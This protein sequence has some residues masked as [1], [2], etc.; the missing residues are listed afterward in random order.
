MTSL[1]GPGMEVEQDK[2]S[3]SFHLDN[4]IMIQ[5]TLSEYQA[6]IKKFVKPEQ[7]PMQPGVVLKHD[8]CP[9]T[10]D[11]REQKVYCVIVAKLQFD[12]TLPSQLHSWQ[13]SVHQLE[14]CNG[15]DWTDLRTRIGEIVSPADPLQVLW[16]GT[17]RLL[18]SGGRR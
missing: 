7:V 10:P 15:Q 4:Y 3:I 8:L 1:L 5:E 14:H 13:D 6:A 2:G 11:P 12:A 9:E 17:T 16:L 18:C